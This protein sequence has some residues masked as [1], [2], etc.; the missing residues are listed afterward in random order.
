MEKS[1]HRLYGIHHIWRISD[2]YF[3]IWCAF[4]INDPILDGT[5]LA[6]WVIAPVFAVG[7]AIYMI[8]LELLRRRKK[9]A[10]QVSFN[11]IIKIIKSEP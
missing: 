2:K 3:G 8:A 9:K 5:P 6:V 7:Y 4:Y 11:Q 1:C 10:K